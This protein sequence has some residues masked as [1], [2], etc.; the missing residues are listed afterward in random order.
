MPHP[1]KLIKTPQR[2]TFFTQWFLFGALK[3]EHSLAP[4][5]VH[6][7]LKGP[8][9]CWAAPAEPARPTCFAVWGLLSRIKVL[10]V[11]QR[12]MAFILAGVGLSCRVLGASEVCDCMA[13][14][15][16]QDLKGVMPADQLAILSVVPPLVPSPPGLSVAP[17]D[18]A[19]WSGSS[20]ISIN[21]FLGNSGE[22]DHSGEEVRWL[23]PCYAH[24]SGPA[25]ADLAV[26][27]PLVRMEETEVGQGPT[28]IPW[29]PSCPLTTFLAAPQI[30]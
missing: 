12:P 18:V 20:H 2:N 22:Q 6:P 30:P 16:V 14:A 21:G 27:S 1:K 13:Q 23:S 28:A 19:F 11:V 9:R 29:G 15:R 17:S 3:S 24:L 26:V 8:Q 5:L 7:G 25:G 10:R 4:Q